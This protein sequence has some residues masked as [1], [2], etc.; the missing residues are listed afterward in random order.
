MHRLRRFVPSANYLFTF[1]AAARRLS[2]TEAAQ[3]LNVSQPAV[4]K[5]IRLLEEATGLQL[6]HRAHNRLELTAEGVRFHREVRDSLDRLYA[7]IQSLKQDQRDEVVRV[8]FSASFVQFWL[9]PRLADFRAQHP[10]VAL[11]IEESGR[12]D[13][14]L[15]RE[16]IDLSA[17][18]GDGEWP[19][20]LAWH[21]ID[22]VIFPVCGPGYL[23][24]PD[25]VRSPADLLDHVLLDF[26]E[27]HRDRMRWRGWLN[28]HKIA[29]NQLHQDFVFTDALGSI[30]AAILGQGIALGWAHLVH[31]Q[32]QD[33]QL[34]RPVSET[35]RS[36][37][38]IYL[39][40][41]ADR[42]PK[43]GAELFRDWILDRMAGT[44]RYYDRAE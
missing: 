9:L 25:L 41:A 26:E 37:Q 11:R 10:E 34:L 40:M 19:G 16:D 8:S 4:S 32:L 6:F 13:H 5:T 29:A 39:V 30:K 44:A 12:D 43:R 24:D 20:L 23:R 1:E 18:L 22:E 35:H 38:S 17:R 7:V 36:G 14:D 28:L 2:F 15:D 21:L 42:P 3:E 27:R 33:G 31:D